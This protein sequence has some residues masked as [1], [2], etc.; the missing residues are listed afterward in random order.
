VTLPG[1]SG[2]QRIQEIL[3]TI[4]RNPPQ[5]IAGR[6]VVKFTRLDT[7]E[8][9]INGKKAASVDLPPSDVFLFDLKDGSRAIV[10]PSGTEPK[11]KFYFFLC[12][13]RS[14][15]SS[16]DVKKSYKQLEEI[17]RDFEKQFLTL[18]GL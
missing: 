14:G 17:S 16:D 10:R 18:I 6:D 15:M 12:D 5:Q 9:F 11:I 13:A 1:I 8:V 4:R 2:A 7:G 3:N